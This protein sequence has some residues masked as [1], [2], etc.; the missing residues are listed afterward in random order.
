[1]TSGALAEP[2]SDAVEFADGLL[3]RFELA[4]KRIHAALA[5][6]D[7]LGLFEDLSGAFLRHDDHPVLIGDDDVAGRT[8]TPA[9]STGTFL[10]TVA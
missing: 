1:M 6:V 7:G 5:V 10:A 3:Q 9:H 4:N 8:V 2:A